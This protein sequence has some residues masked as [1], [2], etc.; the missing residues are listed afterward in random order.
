MPKR[1][2]GKD[3]SKGKSRT[4]IQLGNEDS[5]TL[6][7]SENDHPHRFS[8]STVCGSH[9]KF[10]DST[11][12]LYTLCTQKREEAENK[13]D[14]NLNEDPWVDDDDGDDGRRTDEDVE[15]LEIDEEEKQDDTR[16]K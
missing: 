5:S 4:S 7:A 8:R 3:R 13:M 15:I 10:I 14:F 9:Q 6:R 12:V 2:G 16:V 1:G 11:C